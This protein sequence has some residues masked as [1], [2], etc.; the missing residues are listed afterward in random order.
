VLVMAGADVKLA[1][2]MQGKFNQIQ[3]VMD[4]INVPSPNAS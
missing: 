1:G 2:T 4:N 3:G